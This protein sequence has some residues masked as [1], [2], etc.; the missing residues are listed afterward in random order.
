MASFALHVHEIAANVRKAMS[1]NVPTG[2][3]DETGFHVGVEP[4]AKEVK[5]PPVW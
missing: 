5:W 4:A 1:I 2:Y 3:Q